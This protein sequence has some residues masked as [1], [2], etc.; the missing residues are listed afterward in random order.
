MNSHEFIKLAISL[1]I[2]LTPKIKA[3]L[4][5]LGLSITGLVV[6]KL[7]QLPPPEVDKYDKYRP[8]KRLNSKV[9]IAYV[10]YNQE[11]LKDVKEKFEQAFPKIEIAN[12]IEFEAQPSNKI[13]FHVRPKTEEKDEES[14]EW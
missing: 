11:R 9:Y 1:G 5:L 6:H 4:T 8:W 10:G 7:S 3:I 12:I 2:R 13:Y 14:A